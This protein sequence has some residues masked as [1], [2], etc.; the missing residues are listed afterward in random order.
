M[1]DRRRFLTLMGGALTSLLAGARSGPLSILVARHRPGHPTPRPGIDGSRVLTAEQVG[2]ALAEL[3]DA[4]RAI[5]HVVD[6]IRCQCGCAEVP[7]MYSLL[8]C[9]EESG[10]AR[11]CEICQ[12]EGR[13]VSRL[14][15]EGRALDEVRAEIDRQ[16]G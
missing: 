10:M 8:S 4:V 13:L 15:G 11:Y 3:Y 14:H 12:G 16:F 6:G 1:A 7:G 9:Y 2:P 5:P